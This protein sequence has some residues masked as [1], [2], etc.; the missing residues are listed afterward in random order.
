M[1]VIILEVKK[2]KAHNRNYTVMTFVTTKL[3]VRP[4]Y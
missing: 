1:V 3:A 2:V 4:Q